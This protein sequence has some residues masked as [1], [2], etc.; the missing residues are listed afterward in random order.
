MKTRK[1]MFVKLITEKGSAFE[2]E[3]FLRAN[4]YDAQEIRDI[5]DMIEDSIPDHI[6]YHAVKNEL[7]C[8][9]YMKGE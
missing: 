7:D 9:K 1:E 3:K 2:F 5:F 6:E 8:F 4:D